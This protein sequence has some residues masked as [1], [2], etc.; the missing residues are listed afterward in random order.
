MRTNLDSAT[1]APLWIVY[2]S[3][4]FG[5]TTV[6]FTEALTDIDLID[7]PWSDENPSNLQSP[8]TQETTPYFKEQVL[9]SSKFDFLSSFNPGAGPLC[10]LE[11][12]FIVVKRFWHHVSPL[13]RYRGC[14]TW[15]H[16]RVLRVHALILLN[17]NSGTSRERQLLAP[18]VGSSPP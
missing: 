18:K 17:R 15:L 12:S 3:W 9:N 6:L 14:R 11:C 8:V 13:D 4:I 2:H 7:D 16:S 1:N 5:V 10:I